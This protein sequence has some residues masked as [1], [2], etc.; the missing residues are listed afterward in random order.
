MFLP[1]PAFLLAAGAGAEGSTLVAIDDR[2]FV[3]AGDSTAP[4]VAA[5]APELA[6]EAALEEPSVSDI[7]F[8][9]SS[10]SRSSEE[11]DAT[12]AD[13]VDL[14]GAAAD[15][16]AGIVGGAEADLLAALIR[17]VTSSSSSSS[18]KR[19][20]MANPDN[21]SLAFTPPGVVEVDTGDVTLEKL[22]RF[23]SCGTGS[24][25]LAAVGLGATKLLLPTFALPAGLV[26]GEM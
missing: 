22:A 23:G 12:P 18:N 3:L 16:D 5:A 14:I 6:L 4:E 1:I 20:P 9:R 11:A 10:T 8:R 24:T 21:I 15:A 26:T 13:R 25:G 17:A 19:L 2:L 7:K